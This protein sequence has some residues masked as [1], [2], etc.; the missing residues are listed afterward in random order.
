M[1]AFILMLLLSGAAG[2]STEAPQS[3]CADC[4]YANMQASFADHISDWESSGHGRAMIGCERCHGGDPTT[5]EPLIAHRD[6]L[7]LSHRGSPLHRLNMP[8]TCGKCHVGAFAAFQASRHYE[9]LRSGSADGPTCV[10]CHDEVAGTLLSPRGLENQCASCHGAGKPHE[11]TDYPPQGR[12]L[13]QGVRDVREQLREAESLI[14]HVKDKTRR[15]E[16][17]AAAQQARVPLAEASRAGHRFVFDQLEER[18]QTA[19]ERAS[20]LLERLANQP[21]A[22]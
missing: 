22:R 9:L 11:K 10:T 1:S 20:A 12:R 21:P 14:R 17:E 19:R 3:R 6:I 8:A 18:L 15:A 16:L 7:P 5:F 4:H 2:S 13:L